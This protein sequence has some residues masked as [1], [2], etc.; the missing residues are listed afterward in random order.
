M[1][2]NAK[3]FKKCMNWLHQQTIDIHWSWHADAKFTMLFSSNQTNLWSICLMGFYLTMLRTNAQTTFN[4]LF[5]NCKSK[6]KREMY[7]QR[8]KET[9]NF[10]KKKKKYSTK[11][12]INI[13]TQKANYLSILFFKKLSKALFYRQNI[14]K[15]IMGY[16]KIWDTH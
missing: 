3:I 4:T 10:K 9:P 7:V 12:S 16:I 1:L 5:Q 2:L 11:Q 6:E 8:S 14:K 15:H 13:P